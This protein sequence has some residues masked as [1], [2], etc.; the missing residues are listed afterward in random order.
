MQCHCEA[1]EIAYV[2]SFFATGYSAKIAKQIA[3]KVEQSSNLHVAE[4]VT[5]CNIYWATCS[6]TIPSYCL[7]LITVK[8]HEK[9]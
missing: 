4:P 2:T 1:K 7:V 5:A 6:T 8:N 9:L 3:K